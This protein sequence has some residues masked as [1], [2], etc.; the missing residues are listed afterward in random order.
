M[1]TKVIGGGTSAV[2]ASAHAAC[3]RFR[4]T[5][6]LITG[7]T[8]RNLA[9]A[10]G[11][12]DQHG[13]IPVA[14]WMHAMTFERLVRDE[15]FASEVATTAVGSLGLDRPEAVVIADAQ[16]DLV[17]TADA[18]ASAH[19]RAVESNHVTVIHGLAV[20]FV[21]FEHQRA[22]DVKP[23]FAIVV[24]KSQPA[25]ESW[26]ILGDA[27]DFE[28]VRSRIDDV[29]LLKGFL[30]VALGAESAAAWT[31]LPAGMTVH[32]SGVLA[33]PRNA[34][35]QPTA[36][37]E[38]LD[39]H[40]REVR[41]R[42]D[43]RLREAKD[44]D[45]DDRQPID[46]F[47]RHL[48]ATFAPNTCGSCTLFSFCR[49]ELR[50]SA[51]PTD[52]LI[53]IGVPPEARPHV[54]G[55]LDGTGV[56]G[57]PTESVRLQVEATATGRLQD[58]GQLRVDPIGRP[59]TL[60]VVLAK[61]DG[62]TLGVYG[63]SVQSITSKGFSDW[64]TTVFEDPQGAATRKQLMRILGEE[65]IGLI[66]D[67]RRA[68]ADNPDPVHVVVPDAT[69]ADLLVSIADNLAGVELSRLRWEAD[70]AAG[71]PALTFNGEP[72]DIPPALTDKERTGVSF[73]LEEDRG[74]ALTLRSPIVD[75]RSVM[76]R[77]FVAG[78][79]AASAGRLDYLVEW[80]RPGPRNAYSHRAISD[81]IEARV[82]T[83][84]ARLANAQSDAIH[85]AFVGTRPVEV[86][87]AQP[88]LY[89][90][91]VREELA[92]KADIMDT[93]VAA[94]E[95]V[96]AS[97]LRRVHRTIEGDAQEV[98]RRRLS[99]HASDL[100]RF[101][102]TSRGWRNALVPVIEGDDKLNAQLLAL[103]NRKAARDAALD[104][105][106]RHIAAATVVSVEPIV[107]DVESRRMGEGSRVV[108]LHVDDEACI[109]GPGVS[110]KI[111]KG[112][113]KFS[114][115]SIGPL[116]AIN[117]AVRRF[118]WQPDTVPDLQPGQ[119]LVIADFAWFTATQKNNKDLPVD[120]PKPD[121]FRAP[122][123]DC[124][125]TSYRDNPDA[126]AWCCRS[127]E[128]A[129]AEAAQRQAEQRALGKLN[130]Q[131]WPPIV[132]ADG[133]EVAAAGAPVGDATAGPLVA[134]PDDLTADDLD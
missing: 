61:S 64:V 12:A 56:V 77:H 96:P 116:T 111:Q 49:A 9:K 11:F 134:I 31:Q 3:A 51:D 7:L 60:H 133:F 102:R 68:D 52:I 5:D 130:P 19:L 50:A 125:A 66:K 98:W 115:L 81:D 40:R 91:L 8:R 129:E 33:V 131:A 59:G 48:Q 70:R 87:P 55:I 103:S 14:R 107:L 109:E 24:R 82:H 108:L 95:M 71:R 54:V 101:G 72:A 128:D 23:D 39:D 47:V 4:G 110:M 124:T 34:F 121:S 41:M 17:V 92:Y 38:V 97:A 76:A 65:I 20:P 120:R 123:A 57:E 53:E 94:L 74:R 63:V 83:P 100:V 122:R 90:S 86:R 1:V 88:A 43:E 114:G 37:V 105:G 99:L 16:I 67:R 46:D 79:P 132:D 85:E 112:S 126:H 42:V 2:A 58:T 84:G 6:P 25:A 27:K 18:L 69:T 15:R 10:V 80:T 26:L 30:Q 127:H 73:L 29:R 13:G 117:D 32:R 119:R 44:I 22:T 89:D 93:A 75:V 78:G 118:T 106:T 45:F 21:G 35:L 104:A 62:A 113:F 36:V 28:R